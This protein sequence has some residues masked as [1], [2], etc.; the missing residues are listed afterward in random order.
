MVFN[1]D[2]G[3]ISVCSLRVGRSRKDEFWKT[4]RFGSVERNVVLRIYRFLTDY[5][6][7]CNNQ[8]GFRRN[9][10][11]TM[12]L[13]Q[14]ANTIASS[15]DDKETTV[16]VFLDFSKAFDTIDHHILLNK[17]DRYAIRGPALEWIASYLFNR[18]QFVQFGAVCSQSEPITCGVPQGSIL[19]PLLFIIYINDLPNA[20]KVVKTFLFADDTSL[21]YSHKDCNQA[22][23]V[24]NYE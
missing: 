24:M 15:M 12:A 23:A 2:D 8:F 4:V 18:K 19:G 13:I 21:F 16:G 14:L 17:L 1:C 5:N 22:I 11:T 20:S 6:L 7:L 10:S 9:H 3:D